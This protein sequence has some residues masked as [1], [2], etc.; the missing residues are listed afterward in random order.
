[1]EDKRTTTKTG[2]QTKAGEQPVAPG[3]K[4][5][6]NAERQKWLSRGVDD[7]LLQ[8]VFLCL[9]CRMKQDY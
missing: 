2:S 9:V 7:S 8:P 1:M 3:L 4:M 5:A 6:L